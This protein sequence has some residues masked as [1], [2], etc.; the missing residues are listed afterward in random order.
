MNL[1]GAARYE[2]WKAARGGASNPTATAESNT[3]SEPASAPAAARLEG[4]GLLGLPKHPAW[5][6]VQPVFSAGVWAS[7]LGVMSATAVAAFGLTPVIPFRESHNWVGAAGMARCLKLTGSELYVTYDPG[8]DPER[9]SVFAQN[10]ISV[11]D[12]H[13][14][15]SVIPHAF[16]GL[17]N[18]WHFNIPGY[19]WIMRLANGIPVFPRDAGR[20][21]EITEAARARVAQG[22]SILVF[23]E[24]HRTRDGQV[25]DYKRGVFFMARDAGIPVVPIAVRGLRD[26]NKRKSLRFEPG[27]VEVYVGPQLETADLDDAG[28]T[29]LTARAKQF[30]DTWV[31][32]GVAD[33]AALIGQGTS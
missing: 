24:G 1:A 32:T 4:S 3:A 2:R 12:A 6:V 21:A 29:A 19:G 28:V 9:R 30:A 26:V 5:P 23:P 22:I 10:H 20:T 33:T 27:R 18:H 7:A 13:V 8:F 31:R 16:C 14:A 17:M 11:L 25:Q 15:C